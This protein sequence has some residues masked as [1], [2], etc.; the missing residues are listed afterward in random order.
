MKVVCIIQARMG[1]SRLPGKVLMDIVGAPMLA[2]VVARVR[3][4]R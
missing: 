4:A 1:S 2:R 3:R